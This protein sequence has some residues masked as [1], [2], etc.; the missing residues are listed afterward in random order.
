MLLIHGIGSTWRVWT[1]I[2]GRLEQRHEVLAISLPGYG[3]S[4]PLDE[5]PTVPALTA[6]VERELDAV[7]WDT[8]HVVGNSLGGWIA[9]ELAAHG[10]A[11]SGVAVDPAGLFTRKELRYSRATL[12]QSYFS[13]KR[14]AP[15]ADRLTGNPIM[16]QLL[17]GQVQTR[18]WRNDPEEAAYAIR[19]MGDSP[20][21]LKTLEWIERNHAQPRGLNQIDCPFLVVWGTW[22][23]LLLPR[24]A[25]RWVDLVPGAELKLLP[26]LGHV[27]MADDPEAT[28]EVIEEFVA[29]A[30]ARAEALVT[31]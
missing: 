21:F 3:E 11:R 26:R 1:P 2:L 19:A 14:I 24:M 9:A 15:M 4:A 8:A 20:S 12:R 28:A 7:G 5:E 31:R 6:A 29:R 23:V 18:G 27:P 22:D 16:R 13:A 25:R 10:R 17:F 30:G